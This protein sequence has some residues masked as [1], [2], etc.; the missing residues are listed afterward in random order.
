MNKLV[1]LLFS[2]MMTVGVKFPPLLNWAGVNST[3]WSG[4]APLPQTSEPTDTQRSPEASKSMPPIQ[5]V[6]EPNAGELMLTPIVGVISPVPARSAA[7][8]ITIESPKRL[9]PASQRFPESSKAKSAGT[10]SRGKFT[11]RPGFAGPLEVLS[12]SANLQICA[13]LVTSNGNWNSTT[14]RLSDP[15][16]RNFV[17]M[18]FADVIVMF[19]VGPPLFFIFLGQ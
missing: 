15:S 17:G 18:A 3:S 6:E 12:L 14:Q 4:T 10:K 19:G 7:A 5:L 9:F 8:N 13:G 1:L 11:I 2:P 16:N